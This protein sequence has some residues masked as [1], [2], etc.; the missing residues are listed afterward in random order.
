MELGVYKLQTGTFIDVYP[1]KPSRWCT[2]CARKKNCF[3]CDIKP[4][5][6][7]AEV[8]NDETTKA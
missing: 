4:K 5:C 3:R 8:D 1:Q 7:V 6:F 2:I